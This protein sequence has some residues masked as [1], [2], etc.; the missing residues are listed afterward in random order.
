MRTMFYSRTKTLSGLEE[1]VWLYMQ[2]SKKYSEP[3]GDN[4]LA[5]IKKKIKEIT[6]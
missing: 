6:C 1:L 5:E 2:L 4:W 3:F